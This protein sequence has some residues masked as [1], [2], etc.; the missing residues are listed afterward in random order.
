MDHIMEKIRHDQLELLLELQQKETEAARISAELEKLPSRI[1]EMASV[2]QRFDQEMALQKSE[3]DVLRKH[4][5]SY[6]ADIQTHQERVKKRN[7]QLDA[8]KTNKE[9]QAILKEIEEIRA[10]VSRMEDKALEC[11]DSIE[12][13]EKGLGATK[14]EYASAAEKIEAE[15]KSAEKEADEWKKDYQQLIAERDRLSGMIDP[16]LLR[17]Y[18]SVKKTIGSP[19]IVAASD[20]VCQGCYMNIPPQMYNELHRED[21]LR[22][23]PHCHRLLYVL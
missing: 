23:C 16:D 20:A 14:V 21:E 5:R 4:Y 8:V 3:I 9:Y 15:K 6:D 7:I 10:A 17:E 12:T 11:L 2:L 13:A 22:I 19:A 1:E 18:Q